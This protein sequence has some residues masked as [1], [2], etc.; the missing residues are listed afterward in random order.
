[1]RP[2]LIEGV[3][4]TEGKRLGRVVGNEEIGADSQRG[5]RR[6]PEATPKLEHTSALHDR[7]IAGDLCCQGNAT[8]PQLCPVRQ[9]LLGVGGGIVDQPVIV[10]GTRDQQ[11]IGRTWQIDA[12]N[13]QRPDCGQLREKFASSGC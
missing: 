7:W 1:L 3:E 12:I 8:G 10:D 13:A 4:R 2:C 6:H 9:V 5:N 11:R